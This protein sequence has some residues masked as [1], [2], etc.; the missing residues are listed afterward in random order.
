[1]SVF[2]F[3]AKTLTLKCGNDLPF[4]IK[5]AR[6]T[7]MT[8]LRCRRSGS[9]VAAYSGQL[10]GFR[11]L[12]AAAD[13]G[14]E[15]LENCRYLDRH[16]REAYIRPDK[17]IQG[18]IGRAEN[19]DYHA[20]GDHCLCRNGRIMAKIGTATEHGKGGMTGEVTRYR[21]EDRRDRP[22]RQQSHRQTACPSG[23]GALWM[24]RT[25]GA[26]I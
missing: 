8:P 12:R 14:Y 26:V 1:M 21:C 19:M 20:P 11:F 24:I 4:F 15:R 5:S 7:C 3:S 23:P 22:Y 16:K 25:R 18:T 17:E 10:S 2:A 9:N 13:P 6:F